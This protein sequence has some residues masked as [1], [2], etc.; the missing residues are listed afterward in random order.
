MKG[1]GEVIGVVD[2]G[3]TKVVILVAQVEKDGRLTVLGAGSAPCEDGLRMGMVI[4]IGKVVDALRKA[5]ADAEKMSDC[6]ISEV[7]VGV[8]G[9]HVA[10][11]NNQAMVS[12]KGEI[13]RED[14]E[15]VL[16]LAGKLALPVDRKVM[17]ILPRQYVVNEHDGI[18]DPVGMVG[19]RLDAEVH[20]VTA[21]ASALDNLK[22]CCERAGL[23]VRQF[24]A[25]PVA[26][27][28]AVLE[29]HER[30]LGAAV[31]DLGGGTTQLTIWRGG[32]LVHTR[33]IG[34]GGELVT[35]D[36]ALGLR[37]P[38]SMAE[39]L[40]V[41]HGNAWTEL[42][43]AGEQISLPAYGPRAGQ[44][45]GRRV[46][47]EIIEPRV[48]EILKAVEREIQQAQ[49]QDMLAA[50]VVLTGG[51]SQLDG[52]VEFAQEVLNLPVRQGTARDPGSLGQM[53]ASPVYATA[54]GLALFKSLAWREDIP[55]SMRP[56]SETERQP[57]W[58]MRVMRF[59]GM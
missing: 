31:V 32:R 35:R 7:V 33:V 8:G 10:G 21:S 41:R 51:G 13:T 53:L 22:R 50:G 27:A 55:Y 14:V 4:A 25:N 37:L 16:R 23:R 11:V 28:M 36:I 57:G 1:T 58:W 46:L 49:G 30:E 38:V 54:Y 26:S 15:R 45:M 47:T 18:Q 24:V 20:L 12:P 9:T 52:V 2:F 3:T 56:V 5:R 42:V 59:F 19:V 17:D 40:K 44:N 43:Q 48:I 39:E 29:D 34:L 6:L